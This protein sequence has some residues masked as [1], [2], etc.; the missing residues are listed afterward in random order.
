MRMSELLLCTNSRM[1]LKLLRV[2]VTS[3]PFM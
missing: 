3:G 2:L 1:S